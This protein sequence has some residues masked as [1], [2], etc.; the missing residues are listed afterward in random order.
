MATSRR[1]ARARRLCRRADVLGE[2]TAGPADPSTLPVCAGWR[3]RASRR[4][5]HAMSDASGDNRWK[6]T[7]NLPRTEFP[8]KG[9]LTQLE[10]RIL[11]RWEAEGTYR[12]LLRKNAQAPRFVF[13]D[14]PPYAN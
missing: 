9:N 12:A 6:Q 3:T 4:A 13:L 8:M 2:A 7:L 10:P 11:A 14:G 1:P 5:P